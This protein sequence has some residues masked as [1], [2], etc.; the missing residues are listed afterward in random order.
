[1]PRILKDCASHPVTRGSHVKKHSHNFVETFDGFLGFGLNRQSN[2]DTLAVYLQKF[3]DDT[4]MNTVL[5][6][7]S[8]DDLETMFDII[9]GMLK[10][11]LTDAEYHRI[12][13]KDER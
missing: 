6:K 13:L 4:L 9:T 8:D 1:V 10:R 11:Y 2:E 7:M 5:K 12:F 3:S